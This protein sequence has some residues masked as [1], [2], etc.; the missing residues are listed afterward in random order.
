[1]EKKARAELRPHHVGNVAGVETVSTCRT[2]QIRDHTAIAPARCPVRE[3]TLPPF[4]AAPRR[5]RHISDSQVM[6]L[7]RQRSSKVEL[8]RTAARR[9]P[10]PHSNLRPHLITV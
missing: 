8:H 1:M 3:K 2:A 6:R 7:L 10:E 4:R 9:R 5:D